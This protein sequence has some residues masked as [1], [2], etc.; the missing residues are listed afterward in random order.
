VI[1]V[2]MKNKFDE[3]NSKIKKILE[4]SKQLVASKD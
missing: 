1:E 4:Q 3:E 2:Q